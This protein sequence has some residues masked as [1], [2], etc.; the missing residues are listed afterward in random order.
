[1]EVILF[2]SRIKNLLWA[3]GIDPYAYGFHEDCDSDCGEEDIEIFAEDWRDLYERLL[4]QQ[5]DRTFI[6]EFPNGKRM[7]MSEFFENVSNDIGQLTVYCPY[8][9]DTDARSNKIK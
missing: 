8:Q 6:V 5:M 3:T 2:I 9:L 4:I 7:S 1:M